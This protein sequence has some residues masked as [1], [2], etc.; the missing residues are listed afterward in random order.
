MRGGDHPMRV[1]A[2]VYAQQAIG[3]SLDEVHRAKDADVRYMKNT[4]PLLDIGWTRRD[5]HAYLTAHGWAYAERRG[6]IWRVKCKKPDGTWA[7]ESGFD[8]KES[9]LAWGRDQESDIRRN[10]WIDLTHTQQRFGPFAERVFATARLSNNTRAKYRPIWT[11]TPAAV[12]GLA[13]GSDLQ[14]LLGDRAVGTEPAR[15]VGRANS[16]VRVRVRLAIAV[17]ARKMP[18]NPA[19]DVRVTTG[20]YETERHVGRP[21]GCM[22]P[23]GGPGSCW[24]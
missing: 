21:C 12:E 23:S 3:I 19:R 10:T 17:K 5:C 8:T 16:G 4:F 24:P 2:G 20:E 7:S 6:R 15:E 13:L 11:A 9:A 18:A 22:Y 14:R 1:P